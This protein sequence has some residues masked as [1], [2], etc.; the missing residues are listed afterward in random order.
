MAEDAWPGRNTWDPKKLEGYYGEI[1]RVYN[2]LESEKGSYMARC[3]ALRD[4][5]KDI[6]ETAKQADGIPKKVMKGIVKEQGLLRKAEAIRD[7]MDDLQDDFD[8]IKHALGLLE[9]TPLGQ[10]ALAKA[11]N[12]AEASAPA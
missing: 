10:A 11:G 2:E 5:I 7:D 6:L 4:E 8:T 1:N 12:G 9:D 3:K